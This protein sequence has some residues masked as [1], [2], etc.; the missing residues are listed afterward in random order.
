MMDPI[1][2]KL[3][4]SHRGMP[5]RRLVHPRQILLFLSKCELKAREAEQ[6]LAN[7]EVRAS[8]GWLFDSILM[9]QSPNSLGSC[10]PAY[11]EKQSAMV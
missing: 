1:P 10:S 6:A 11:S 7:L 2:A 9:H 4:A 5:F 3:G 8:G